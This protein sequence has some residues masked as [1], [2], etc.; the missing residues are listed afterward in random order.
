VAADGM[1]Y[2]IDS[3]QQEFARYRLGGTKD[4]NPNPTGLTDEYCRPD[5]IIADV[6]L[7]HEV[8]DNCEETRPRKPPFPTVKAGK[9]DMYNLASVPNIK[10]PSGQ[11]RF[12]CDRSLNPTIK[13]END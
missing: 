8:I 2:V 1:V 7:R 9:Y 3:N 10:T 5:E 6:K 11:E 13:A 12:T 4:Q